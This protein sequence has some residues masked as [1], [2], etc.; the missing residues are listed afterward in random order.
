MIVTSELQ[1]SASDTYK[2]MVHFKMLCRS[3]L[4]ICEVFKIL[5]VIIASGRGQQENHPV[6]APFYTGQ[7]V[8]WDR[9]PLLPLTSPAFS[10][11]E[12]DAFSVSLT[13]SLLFISFISRWFTE[14]TSPSFKR[15]PQLRGSGATLLQ[16][17]TQDTHTNFTLNDSMGTEV[18]CPDGGM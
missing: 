8:Q 6:S 18:V 2:N 10:I 4:Q 7:S 16:C 14:G 9:P 13:Y 5:P 15:N 17:A 3:L 11:K 12:E 1:Q